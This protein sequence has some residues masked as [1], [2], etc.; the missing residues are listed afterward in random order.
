MEEVFDRGIA[1][2][3][4]GTT[5]KVFYL[6]ILEHMCQR[7]AGYHLEKAVADLPGETNYLIC[8]NDISILV[9][10]YTVGTITQIVNSR[11]WV[12]NA[13]CHRYRN[14][15]WCVFL[16]YDTDDYLAPVTKFYEGDWVELRHRLK[17]ANVKTVIDMAASADIEDLMLCDFQGVLA[18]L[19]IPA[20]SLPSGKKGKTKMKKLFKIASRTYHEGDRAK[21]LIDVLDK[22]VVIFHALVPFNELEKYCFPFE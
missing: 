22:D 14:L 9:K 4:E 6:S 15:S 10:T 16:C 3:F 2:V 5:E 1:F 19:K 12:I 7:H 17:E 21:P 18:H 11:N 13:C 20:C 8:K